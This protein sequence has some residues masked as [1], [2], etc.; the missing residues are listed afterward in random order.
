MTARK[1]GGVTALV[2]GVLGAVGG[3]IAVA[4]TDDPVW[5]PYVVTLVGAVFEV[6]GF[7]IVYPGDP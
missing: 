7:T 6:F 4:A 1:K 5:W 2:V 3:L